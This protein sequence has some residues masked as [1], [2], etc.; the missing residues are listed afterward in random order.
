M[1]HEAEQFGLFGTRPKPAPRPTPAIDPDFDG[2]TFDEKK[3]G[4]RL[5]GQWKRVYGIMSD[6]DW[7]TLGQL[8]RLTGIPGA[9]LSARIRDFRKDKFG[10]HTVNRRRAKSE[11]GTHEYQLVINKQEIARC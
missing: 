6:G 1:K 2:G 7:Y 4:A 3:D 8:E 10:G 5:K 11:G 9:S